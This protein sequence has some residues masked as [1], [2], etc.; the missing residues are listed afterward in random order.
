[1]KKKNFP[2]S[3]LS[4][5]SLNLES[6]VTSLEDNLSQTVQGGTMPTWTIAC[7]GYTGGS[8]CGFTYCCSS[9]ACHTNIGVT[10]NG[11]GGPGC[12]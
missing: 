9:I 2:K 3:K 8:N 10:C 4:L 7:T 12:E 1:M 5:E 6:F 11:S